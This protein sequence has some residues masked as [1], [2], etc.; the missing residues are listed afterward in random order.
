MSGGIVAFNPNDPVQQ[1]FLSALAL[2]EGG[3]NPGLYEGFGGINLSNAPTD[4]SG[5]PVQ[6]PGSNVSSA[7]GPFQFVKSTWDSLA[8]KFGLNFS[9]V[10]DQEAGAWYLAQDTYSMNTGGSLYG[11]LSAGNFGKVD[12]ALSKVWP[13]VMGNGAAPA[14]LAASL[15][16]GQGANIPF[17]VLPAAM[18][19]RAQALRAH[20][21]K[22]YSD[23]SKTGS[24]DLA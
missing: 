8:S 4:A 13:S 20:N 12:Q 1:S 11:D 21:L 23:Q 18:L 3:S 16:G 2:G 7:A 9:N 17:P 5:F 22:A 19:A 10:S 24:K 14:G 15:A 6:V